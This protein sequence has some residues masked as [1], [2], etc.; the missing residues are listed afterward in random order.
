MC[1]TTLSPFLH[2]TT[3]LYA[4]RQ[5][6][7]IYMS[8]L[9]EHSAALDTVSASTAVLCTLVFPPGYKFLLQGP[10]TVWP[11]DHRLCGPFVFGLRVP[12]LERCP[13]SPARVPQQYFPSYSFGA[14]VVSHNTYSDRRDR[15]RTRLARALEVE[16]CFCS[17]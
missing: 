7:K 10:T 8:K 11:C 9:L 12:S 17:P 14:L 13:C 6:F 3:Y 1:D 5:D 2:I 15:E 16:R 4:L